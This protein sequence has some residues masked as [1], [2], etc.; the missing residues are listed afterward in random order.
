MLAP[1]VAKANRL[2][3]TRRKRGARDVSNFISLVQKLRAGSRRRVGK[4]TQFRE[5]AVHMPARAHPLDDFLSRV[6]SL[7]VVDVRMFQPG[8][9]R[10]LL[11]V[12]IVAKP[13]SPTFHPD[14]VELFHSSGRAAVNAHPLQ[15]FTPQNG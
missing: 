14:V 1:Q 12:V 2:A 9:V 3:E 5:P 8:L 7:F 13:W 4:K 10:N 6:A 11:I 15:K